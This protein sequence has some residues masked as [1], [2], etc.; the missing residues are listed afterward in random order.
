[1]PSYAIDVHGTL[2]RR[3]PGGGV[4]P[5]PLFEL[6][7]GLMA[8]WVKQGDQVYVLSGPTKE[9]IQRELDSLSLRE[10]VHYHE[11]LSVVEF[12]RDT[13]VPVWENP[14][15]SGHWWAPEENWDSAKGNIV[16]KYSI[17]IIVDDT[18]SYKDAMPPGVSFVL[19]GPF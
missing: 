3:A 12:L 15:G 2:A 6:L 16:A 4:V 18:H 9:I 17:N 11:V 8:A 13:G 7:T 1:M 19:V 10:G 5:S 14:V